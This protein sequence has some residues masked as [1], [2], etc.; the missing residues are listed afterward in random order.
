M[1]LVSDALVLAK[2]G[3]SKTSAVLDV[4]EALKNEQEYLVWSAI[5]A[6][7]GKLNLILWEQ[8]KEVRDN[9]NAFRRVKNLQ[10]Q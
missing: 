2:S 7:F 10:T 4:F 6:Q 1:G 9:F 8:P 5:D 3:N